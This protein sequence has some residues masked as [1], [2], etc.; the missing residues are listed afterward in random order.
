M[1]ARLRARPTV[2]ASTFNALPTMANDSPARYRVAA[3]LTSAALSLGRLTLRAMP[4]RS[5]CSA[6]VDG[7]H[8]IP[9]RGHAMNGQIGTALLR[10]RVETG[11][12]GAGQVVLEVEWTG[13]RWGDWLR[14]RL[15]RAPSRQG[16][17]AVPYWLM[18]TLTHS[19]T[20]VGTDSDCF[21]ATRG[22]HAV[23][24]ACP[25]LRR[26]CRSRVCVT[27]VSD[28]PARTCRRPGTPAGHFPGRGQHES[29]P[30]YR[31]RSEVR[32][33]STRCG[34]ETGNHR[35]AASNPRRNRPGAG[36]RNR[37]ARNW[38]SAAGTGR[39][40]YGSAK[41]PRKEYR[42]DPIRGALNPL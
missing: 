16:L 20:F 21:G 32:V 37:H 31:L 24:A 18:L 34:R 36:S 19:T 41:P 10:L 30:R 5:R 12:V 11:S 39:G 35:E 6:T 2:D 1:P 25:G 13:P 3:R 4:R 42:W 15:H 9:E 22:A 23:G 28:T 8:R 14:G 40:L 26:R 33:L 29:R 27:D 38:Q 7:G 17:K